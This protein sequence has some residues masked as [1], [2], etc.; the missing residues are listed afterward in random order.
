M[1]LLLIFC[2]EYQV[3]NAHDRK[4]GDFGESRAWDTRPYRMMIPVGAC[5]PRPQSSRSPT[6]P[7]CP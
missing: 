5:I 6:H 1:A 2:P 4:F 7:I 3:G